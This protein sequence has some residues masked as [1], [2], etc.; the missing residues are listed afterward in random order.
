MSVKR[1]ARKYTLRKRAEA[2]AETR[3]RIVEAAVALHGTLGP[4]HTSV[5]AIAKRAGVQRATV[6]DHFPD[7]PS[8]LQACAGH[9]FSRHPPPGPADWD[10]IAAPVD[11]LRAALTDVYAYHRSVESMMTPVHRDAAV[12]PMVWETAAA[13]SHLRHWERVARS[14]VES[15]SAADHAP[16]RLVAAVDH[17][18]DFQTWRSLVRRHGLRDAD[19]VELMVTLVRCSAAMDADGRTT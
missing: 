11:R 3:G 16:Q 12:K 6:Y 15:L 1:M 5:S 13:R 19:A 2:Q 17:A 9:F 8:L 10:G 4:A 7:E 18:L 14:L